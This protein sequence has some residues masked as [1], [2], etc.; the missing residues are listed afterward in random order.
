MKT[1]YLSALVAKAALTGALLLTTPTSHAQT[2]TR[3]KSFASTAAGRPEGS[4]AQGGLALSGGM[5][6][7][8]MNGGGI[9]N[10]GTL[11]KLSTNGGGFTVIHHFA[12]G[13]E[14]SSPAGRVVVS[15]NTIYGVTYYGGI[16]N[17]GTI[18]RVNTDGSNFSILRRLG[19]VAG[20][21]TVPFSGM[22]LSGSTLYG[23]TAGGGTS[24]RGVVYKINTNG[25]GYQNLHLFGGLTEGFQPEEELTLV[26]NTLFGITALG[27][28]STGNGT[29]FKLGVD[30][31]GFTVLHSFTP[32]FLGISHR[33]TSVGNELYGVGAS[34][35]VGGYV[36]S[37]YKIN[38]NGS[39]FQ[40]VG[41]LAS[42]LSINGALTW[43]GSELLG[44]ATG[45]LSALPDREVIF[46]M[47]TNGGSYHV[48]KT[49]GL[50]DGNFLS[51]EL[52]LSGTFAY[53]VAIYGGEFNN[54]TVYR[55]DV[56]PQLA[57]T[58]A[59]DDVN[60]SWPSYAQDYQLEQSL[61]LAPA[62]WNTVTAVPSDDG[63]NRMVTLP[64]PAAVFHRLRRP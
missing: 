6:Y 39:G 62:S 30:G 57:V 28:L 9:S 27:G 5:L 61:T 15:G 56:R 37:V 26:G 14:G 45:F 33:L 41:Q 55:F 18:Y 13:S 38:T 60:L 29:L 19:S 35:E 54:G 46:Q 21:G 36:S 7:G 40:T 10:N 51:Y 63:T 23:T 3:L 22:L 34:L 58:A 64:T 47:N 59:G 43:T 17:G 32:A 44:V 31:T 50:V 49:F 42:G 25:S 48:L 16:N 2:F 24:D 11:Y 4:F 1:N 53:G 20:D 52:A 8:V 12:G